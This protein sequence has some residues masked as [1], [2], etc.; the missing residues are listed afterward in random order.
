MATKL[1][2]YDRMAKNL[3]NVP[4]TEAGINK[5][6]SEHYAFLWD[7]AIVNYYKSKYC[8][9]QTIGGEFQKDGYALG[10]KKASPFTQEFSL[11]IL[12]LRQNGFIEHAL[13]KW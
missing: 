7:S 2:P 6:L 13:K 5:T 8:K 11:A 10:L 1:S 3:I 9:L 4:N 12:N